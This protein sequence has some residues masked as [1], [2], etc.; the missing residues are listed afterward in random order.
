M[1]KYLA[2]LTIVMMIGLASATLD[3]LGSFKQNTCVSVKQTCASCTYIDVSISYPNSSIAVDGASMVDGGSGIWTYDFCD[4]SQI[5][6]YDVGGRGD[7]DEANE[8]FST[9]FEI[10]GSG[11]SNNLGFYFLIL[12]LSLGIII[13]GF[14]IKDAPVVIFGSFGL[15]FVGLYILFNGI[16]MIKDPVYTW[17]LGLIILGL[18]AYISIKSAHEIITN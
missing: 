18:A 16:D 5:G 1:K 6:R 7:I 11:L 12:I 14:W 9:Y 10:T 3:N 4:T 2:L 17:A 8:S 13:V 15:Y